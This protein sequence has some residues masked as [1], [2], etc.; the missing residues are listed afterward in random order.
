MKAQLI[1]VSFNGER[2]RPEETPDVVNS[3]W[4]FVALLAQHEVAVANDVEQWPLIKDF[5]AYVESCFDRCGDYE[6]S[7]LKEFF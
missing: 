4:K 5:F 3:V 1:Q 2:G 7:R 6:R